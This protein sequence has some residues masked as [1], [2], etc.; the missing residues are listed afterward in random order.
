MCGDVKRD[1]RLR[2]EEMKVMDITDDDVMTVAA[3]DSGK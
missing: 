1:A 3:A 2:V